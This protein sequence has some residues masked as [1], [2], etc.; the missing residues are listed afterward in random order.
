MSNPDQVIPEDP[1]SA[2]IPDVADDTSLAYDEADHP[3]FEDS[4]PSLPTREP[5]AVDDYGVTAEEG[6]HEESLTDKLA[7][8]RPDVS[9]D[10]ARTPHSSTL[11]DEATSESAEAQVA[12]DGEE[13]GGQSDEPSAGW[14]DD[15]DAPVPGPVGRLY[16]PDQGGREDDEPDSVAYDSDELAGLSAEEA[17]MHEV[18]EEDVP[19]D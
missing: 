15:I 18:S 8:E 19:Y 6:L 13:L 16:E 10:D 3:R 4:P 9:P 17:A 7:R 1:A 5:V 12:E 2:G 14:S 11:A